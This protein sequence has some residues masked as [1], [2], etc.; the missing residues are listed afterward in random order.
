MAAS[1][2]PREAAAALAASARAASP[3]SSA[4]GPLH[5]GGPLS[6]RIA[7]AVRGTLIWTER[8]AWTVFFLFVLT[9][10]ALRHVVL[11]G[12]E[13]YRSEIE[14]ALTRAAGHKV[15][16]GRVQA[17]WDGLYPGLDLRDVVVH[18]AKNRAALRLPYVSVTLSW[19]SVPAMALRLHALDIANADLDIRRARNGQISIGGLELKDDGGNAQ[20]SDWILG[21]RRVVI[22]DSRLRWNDEQR[23]AP[24]LALSNIHLVAR[25]TGSRHRV[26]LRGTPPRQLGNTLDLRADLHGESLGDLAVW[27][28]DLYADL[29][30]VDLAALRAWVDYPADVKSGSGSLR[31]WLSFDQTR[32]TQ[33]TADVALNDTL[34][35]LRPDLAPLQLSNVQGRLGARE[36]RHPGAGFSFLRFGSK[37]VTGFEVSGKQVTLTTNDGVRLAPADFTMQTIAANA[38]GTAGEVRLQANALN[39]EPVVKIAELLPLD[40]QLR[41]TLIELEPHGTVHDFQ[42]EWKGDF[43]QPSGYRIRGRFQD[44]ALRAYQAMPGFSQLSGSVDASEKGGSLYLA[45][46]D[47]AILL[48]QVFETPR[49]TLDTVDAGL[50]WGFPNGQL[51]VK[52]EQIV[53]ANADAAGNVSATY[54]A[55]PGTPGHIDLNGRL[56]RGNATAVYRYMP[57][58][59]SENIHRWVKEAVEAGQ[60]SDV[61][62][63]LRGNLFDFPFVDPKS[64]DFQVAIKL[65][66]GRLFYADAWPR[67]S[68]IK[69]ELVFERNGMWFKGGYGRPAAAGSAAAANAVAGTILGAKI[70]QFDLKI[71]AFDA[72]PAVVE[73]G[74]NADG[75]TPEFLKFV[76]Q[77]PVAGY[78][79]HFT[80]NAR[81][82]G[83]GKLALKLALPLGGA[84][85]LK[86]VPVRFNGQYTFVNNEIMLDDGLPK[87][88][89]VNGVLA[90]SERGVEVRNIRGE[91][92]GGGFTLA[93]GTR[94][95]GSIAV[96]GDGNFTVPGVAAWLKDPVFGSMTGGAPW[97]ATI[98]IGARGRDITVD[99]PMTG[100]AINLPAPINKAAAEN[101]PLRF[102]ETRAIGA[103]ED[104]W[105][106]TLGR[107]ITARLLRREENG[108]MRVMRAAA[109][110]NEAMPALPRSGLAVNASAVSVDVDDWRAR[111]FGAKP[112]AAATGTAGAA[113]TQPATARAGAAA[114]A[115]SPATGAAA[116]APVAPAAPAAPAASAA[117]SVATLPAPWQI[118]LRADTLTAFGRQLRQ[119]RVNMV[120]E[121]ARWVANLASTE[122]N[123]TLVFIMPTLSSQGRFAGQMRNLVI[124]VT[125]GRSEDTPLDRIGDDMPAVDLLVDDFQLGDK[126]LGKLEIVANNIA[127]EWKI[128][129]LNLTNP[130]GALTATGAWRRAVAAVPGAVARRPIALDFTLNTPD[131]GKL[132]DRL[133]F[134]N[135]VRAGS[136]YLKG[137]IGWE[138]SPTSID[139]ASLRGD[140]ELRVEKGQFL[141]ADPGVGKLLGIMSLQALPRRLTLDFRDVFSEGFA[142]DLMSASSKIERGILSTNDFRM[143]GVSAAVLMTGDTDL[144]RE[145]QNLKVVVLPDL[146]GGMVSVVGVITGLINPLSALASYLA[147]RLL[148]DPLSKAFSFEYA[149]TGSWVDPKIAR[150]Q[151]LPQAQSGESS[152]APGAGGVA[153]GASATPPG[154]AGAGPASGA[155]SASSTGTGNSGGAQAARPGG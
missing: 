22:R 132:L 120:Q 114:A 58:D 70:S 80:D 138:G 124:P 91:G 69:G 7:R 55:V 118:Q 2:H 97:R 143:T 92:L 33:F 34:V 15:L 37:R 140:L 129:T 29:V 148:K 62:F 75:P 145:T 126:K 113:S 8:L 142:Y 146:S 110:V 18:D 57:K 88:E 14:T 49:L 28:G 32:L 56:T 150:I 10:L 107:A 122:A 19:W 20:M 105:N 99:S 116:T 90:F 130:D 68:D 84:E 17:S 46:R 139:Y 42:V 64:G 59:M 103:T 82:A 135:A 131:S 117:A 38:A 133:G 12:V 83:N 9:V 52:L 93:G 31:T 141:K 119:V 61:R 101:W 24:E 23:G 74:G 66:G 96:T 144:A 72:L 40:A 151:T 11:P 63:K 123:G 43:D 4:A 36:L 6:S 125:P 39:L 155:G 1:P 5:Y 76:A 77:S 136:G 21:Q 71:A 152:A 112:A 127:G 35:Q 73:L 50:S 78:I 153:D 65:E 44:L 16:I 87:M 95:N 26:A 85:A 13:K 137:N 102:V 27:R 89:R 30:A 154:G 48:P 79:D 94:P 108:V 41:K 134:V 53:F 86:I 47:A 111:A 45:S 51:E 121:P 100:V 3:V 104:E 60:T 25:N 81:A 54:R 67:A 149:V 115:L 98:N 109:G 128:Q 147:Q 106:F